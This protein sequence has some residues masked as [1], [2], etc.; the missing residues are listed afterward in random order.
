MP[1]QTFTI[2]RARAADARFARQAIVELH[3]REPFDEAALAD[4]LTDPTCYLFLALE[5]DR[6]VGSLNG[7][8]LRHPNRREPAFLLYEIDV[9]PECWNRGIGK[10]LVARFTAEARA[11][12][13]FEVWVVTNQSNARAMAMYTRCGLSRENDDDVML[14]LTF[15]DGRSKPA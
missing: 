3:A 4:F 10:A 14:A 2:V 13:A 12:G 6:V 5:G 15:S 9:R 8:S 1:D 11:A 7:Y